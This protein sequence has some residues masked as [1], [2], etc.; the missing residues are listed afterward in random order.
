M[1]SD[2]WKFDVTLTWYLPRELSECD[3]LHLDTAKLNRNLQSSALDSRLTRYCMPLC[4][5]GWFLAD[6][7]SVN[8]GYLRPLRSICFCVQTNPSFRCSRILHTTTRMGLECK[9]GKYSHCSA[10]LEKIHSTCTV[11]K[12]ITKKVVLPWGMQVTKQELLQV[13]IFHI[14]VHQEPLVFPNAAPFQFHK[15]PVLDSSN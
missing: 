15:V 1:V 14:L 11:H 8:I 3:S 10:K 5:D 2:N 13:A 9:R 7:Q 12:M 4:H 6:L